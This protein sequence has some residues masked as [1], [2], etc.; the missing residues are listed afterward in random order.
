[1]KT[2]RRPSR[3]LALVASVVAFATVA[4]LAGA[5]A[6]YHTE[7]LKLTPVGDAPLRSGFVQNIKANGRSVYAHELFV[8]DGTAARTTYTVTRNFFVFD[9][10]CSGGGFVGRSQVGT[11]V[12]NPAGNGRDDVFV[13][14][15]QVQ[16][17]SSATMVS[18]GPWPTRPVPS[19]I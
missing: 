18:S 17:S 12:T 3:R 16:P 15:E 4:P 13:R 2:A 1:M 7:H 5:D 11:I 9:P 14:P 8:L 19:D 6:V 10:G